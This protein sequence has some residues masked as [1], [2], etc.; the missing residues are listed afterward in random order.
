MKKTTILFA[1]LFTS[2]CL[3][4][5]TKM[6][7]TFESLT[8]VIDSGQVLN[9]KNNLK[10]FESNI[11]YQFGWDTSY[12]GYWA[13]NWAASRVIYNKEEPSDFSK[14]LYAAKPG[15]G[16]ESVDYDQTNGVNSKKVFLVGQNNSGFSLP[17]G[18]NNSYQVSQLR[19]SNST[20]SYNSMKFGD[21][22]GKKFSAKDKDSFVLIISGYNSAVKKFSK[23]VYL[24]DF[25][26][27]D[28]TKN[29]LLDTW[30]IVTFNEN[31]IAD[32]LSFTLESSDN[33]QYGMNTPAFFVLDNVTIM[34]HNANI[35]HIAA[36]SVRAFPN[37]ASQ[38]I[39][40]DIPQKNTDIAI[41][42]S[43]GQ[44]CK[45]LQLTENTMEVNIQD[46]A[47]GL[48]FVQMKNEAGQSFITKF[49]KQ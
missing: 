16:C 34:E 7:E 40:F 9:G 25:R 8:A 2:I 44:I 38:F 48:Y 37:P 22:V 17:M 47:A 46:L 26:F 45:K 33:G 19:I 24:A 49:I 42:Q 30:Q 12:G 39:R 20:Y 11:V 36:T 31:E 18:I 13:K 3:N 6:T 43:N 21:F 28:T 23:R 5:Q 41:A 27:A 32:S 29:F 14:H 10:K 4:A 15:Y 1:I 35:K